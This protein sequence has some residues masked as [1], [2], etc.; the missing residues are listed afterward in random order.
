MTNETNRTPSPASTAGGERQS[1]GDD[2]EFIVLLKKLVP[3]SERLGMPKSRAL[4]AH[5]DTWAAR[6]AGD[7]LPANVVID[8]VN[9]MLWLYRRL[10]RAYE[11][12]LFVEKSIT[13][14]ADI[15]G[16][17]VGEYFTE[18]GAAPAPGNT[19]QPCGKEE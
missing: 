9:M 2:P 6:S 3:A 13:D 17:E 12:P 5:I 14:L 4:V 15:V 7:A 18:R 11:R 1:I 10:P 19:A 16:V 8:A